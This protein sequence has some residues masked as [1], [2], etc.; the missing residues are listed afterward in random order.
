MKVNGGRL[1]V[2]A[3][4]SGE[5]P[6]I[7]STATALA[8]GRSFFL[9]CSGR[10]GGGIA[11]MVDLDG[12]GIARMQVR[13]LVDRVRGESQGGGHRTGKGGGTPAKLVR[14]VRCNHGKPRLVTAT[15]EE[16]PVGHRWHKENVSGGRSLKSETEV[17][18]KV[19]TLRRT[20]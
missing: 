18:G 6:R 17:G 15:G 16:P 10:A 1:V 4:L 5:R 13:V 14:I 2:G 11:C 9:R 12:H 19:S 8:I 7:I 3:A 20:R